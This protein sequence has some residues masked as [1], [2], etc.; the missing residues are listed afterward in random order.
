MYCKYCKAEIDDDSIY[1]KKCGANV[2]SIIQYSISSNEIKVASDR[3]WKILELYYYEQDDITKDEDIAHLNEV[4]GIYDKIIKLTNTNA[5]YFLYRG[6]AK[7]LSGNLTDGSIDIDK[8]LLIK[9]F[10][11]RAIRWKCIVAAKSAKDENSYQLL[12]F[13]KLLRKTEEI[14]ND[15]LNES[16]VVTREK[17]IFHKIQSRMNDEF[18]AEKKH[19]KDNFSKADDDFVPF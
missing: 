7:F 16:V 17:R 13:E 15:P 14:F 5:Y 9:P 3:A 12:R 19:G 1:C 2:T 4:I 11:E 8:A 18:D 10:Y 6:I